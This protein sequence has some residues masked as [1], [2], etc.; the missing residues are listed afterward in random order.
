MVTFLFVVTPILLIVIHVF[1][2]L[3]NLFLYN[4]LKDWGNHEN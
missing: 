1:G 4:R 2:Q 3:L